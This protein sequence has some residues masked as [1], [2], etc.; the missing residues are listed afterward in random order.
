MFQIGRFVP[1]TTTELPE[2]RSAVVFTRGCPL[3]CRYCDGGDLMRAWT[4]TDL[5]WDH[6]LAQ[7]SRQR[8]TLDTLIFTGGEPLAQPRLLEAI[9]EARALGLRVALHTSGVYPRRFKQVLPLLDWVGFDVK[10]GYRDYA[11]VTGSVAAGDLAYA[12]LQMLLGASVEFECRTTVH[13]DLLTPAKL[14]QLAQMLRAMG[15]TRYAVQ[16][17]RTGAMFDASLSR[18]SAPPAFI[19]FVRASVAPLFPHFRL[20]S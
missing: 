1:L 4:Q 16:F 3:G 10:A 20:Q 7:L 18:A 9:G 15:V 14:L 12:S 17:A 2:G 8:E 6:V 13:A 11:T 19:A 5:T